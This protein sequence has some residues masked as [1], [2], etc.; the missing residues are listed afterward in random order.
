MTIHINMALKPGWEA[1][2]AVQLIGASTGYTQSGGT[3]T[4]AAGGSLTLT[5]GTAYAQSAGTTWSTAPCRRPS[6]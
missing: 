4:A 3:T 6:R 5:P 2:N 1:I